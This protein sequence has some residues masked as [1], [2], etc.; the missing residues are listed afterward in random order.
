MKR[1]LAQ[2]WKGIKEN[3]CELIKL[4]EETYNIRQYINTIIIIQLSRRGVFT[5][6]T[7]KYHVNVKFYFQG[8]YIIQFIKAS[9]F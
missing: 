4:N 5:H 3:E 7:N 1:R 9:M 2:T 6:K 8:S